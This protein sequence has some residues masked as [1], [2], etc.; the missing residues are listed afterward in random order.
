MLLLL[1]F[2]A[3]YLSFYGYTQANK[4]KTQYYVVVQP[5]VQLQDK[6]D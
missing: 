4:K 2:F 3:T 1:L 6:K 5:I